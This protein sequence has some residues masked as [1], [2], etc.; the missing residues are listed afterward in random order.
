[1]LPTSKRMTSGVPRV[2]GLG[3]LVLMRANI[4]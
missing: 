4:F 1:V 2:A 3:A